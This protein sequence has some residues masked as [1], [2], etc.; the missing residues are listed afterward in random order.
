MPV[1]KTL[2]LVFIILA[3]GKQAG[4]A[5]DIER[6]INGLADCEV[7]NC[8]RL[9]AGLIQAGSANMDALLNKLGDTSIS[10]NG[11]NQIIEVLGKIRDSRATE[12]LKNELNKPGAS[13]R[14]RA[15][16]IAALGRIG[17]P[18]AL[19]VLRHEVKGSDPLSA[20]TAF[21]AVAA[22]EE[23]GKSAKLDFDDIKWYEITDE[24]SV[25]SIRDRR[26]YVFLKHKFK[27]LE[28]KWSP[29]DL[30]LTPRYKLPPS[31]ISNVTGLSLG[32]YNL[33]ASLYGI[34][35]GIYN[36]AYGNS[37]SIQAGARNSVDGSL[38]G[39]QV[40]LVDNNVEG[41]FYGAQIGIMYNYYDNASDATGHGIQLGLVNVSGTKFAGIQAGF[42][43]NW[44]S[45]FNGLQLGGVNLNQE[46]HGVQAGIINYTGWY[47]SGNGHCR[48]V[49][50]GLIN[51]CNGTLKGIQIGVLNAARSNALPW[52]IGINAGF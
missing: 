13:S 38:Y 24:V 29:L 39:I 40:A 15:T 43:L 17:D 21:K 41:R 44:N 2:L 52:S 12:P 16:T 35:A 30:S 49:Q 1:Y 10:E 50:L 22:I 11:K 31:Q 9:K 25:V 19:E 48:G 26:K 3:L 27:V 20:Y 37:I 18:S 6:T 8:D 51:V 36:V 23:S 33:T 42:F 7:N 14:S 45:H 32:V 47:E 28:E 5:T 34:Q 4:A 46:F